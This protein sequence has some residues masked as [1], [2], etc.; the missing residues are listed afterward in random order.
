MHKQSTLG[1]KVWANGQRH[2]VILF[3]CLCL[4]FFFFFCQTGTDVSQ[5]SCYCFPTFHST[6]LSGLSVKT[7]I[8]EQCPSNGHGPINIVAVPVEFSRL[9]GERKRDEEKK[10][11]KQAF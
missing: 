6:N 10:E 4:F 7:R 8:S 9:C 2:F 11:E 3:A 1:Q 5:K